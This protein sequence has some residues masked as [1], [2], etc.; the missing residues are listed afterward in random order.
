[1]HLLVHRT[2]ATFAASCADYRTRAH[3]LEYASS[4]SLGLAQCTFYSMS[5]ASRHL[6]R[7]LLR[8]GSQPRI[9][10]RCQTIE[11]HRIQAV[12]IRQFSAVPWRQAEESA[13]QDSSPIPEGFSEAEL[14]TPAKPYAPADLDPEDR[15]HY[16]TLSKPEQ[17]RYMAL[18][19]HLKAVLEG[20]QMSAMADNMAER[21]AAEMDH[22]GPLAGENFLEVIQDRRALT[23]GY[24]AAGEDDDEF[25]QAIDDDDEWD[26]SMVTSVA[27]SEMEVHREIREYTRIAAWDLPM[28]LRM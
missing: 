19:N 24:W 23:N 4:C 27:E 13:S 26:P 14:Q 9:K 17:A 8:I 2:A 3:N 10:R 12:P 28:L 5:T 15:A 21:F 11:R 1:M 22:H 18:Q 6:C 7:Q 20:E 25:T 16:E